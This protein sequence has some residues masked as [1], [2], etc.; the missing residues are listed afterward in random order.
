VIILGLVLIVQFVGAASRFGGEY[1]TALVAGRML[2]GMRRQ[3]YRKALRLPIS[4]YARRGTADVMSRFIQDSQSIYRGLTYIFV[5][6]LREPL[7]AIGAFAV[8]LYVNWQVTLLAVLAAPALLL[9]IRSFG[10][11]I[12]KRARRLLQGYARML[13]ALEGAL[14]GIRVVKGYG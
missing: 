14:I 13:S 3:M 8:A 7:K 2:L 1:L 5:Q 10:K 12:R 11:S 9:M 6:S 4:F